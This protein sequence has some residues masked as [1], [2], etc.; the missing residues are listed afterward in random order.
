VT[1][2]TTSI[3]TLACL[4]VLG[5]A[6]SASACTFTAWKPPG[7][8]N[9][10][11]TQSAAGMIVASQ[12]DGANGQDGAGTANNTSVAR[13]SGK[14]ASKAKAAGNFSFDGSPGA[15]QAYRVRFYVYTG[16]TGG[17]AK[18]FQATDTGGA[19]DVISVTYDPG[20]S[21]FIFNPTGTV[22][23]IQANK[24][25]RVEL[26]WAAGAPM[27]ITVQ[28]AG[29]A[30][31]TT[32]NSS[33]NGA[34]NIETARLGWVANVSGSPVGTISTDAFESRRATAIGPLCRG[35]ANN[36]GSGT[37]IN[38]FDTVTLI[39]EINNPASLALG[40]PDC[41]EDGSVNIFDRVCVV[42]LINAGAT[43]P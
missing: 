30:S 23:S 24:W 42:G 34:G 40:Q 13:Y 18:V 32:I 14:C 5:M 38:V 28:G 21:S 10:G 2:K 12:P 16:I 37:A 6:T 15:E 17:A 1:R 20:A 36:S 25:Y 8:A 39:N 35:D 4:G 11:V 26:N 19:T 29:A 9:G 27:G 3:L 43:C 41:N 33:T 31:P 7:N 22:G